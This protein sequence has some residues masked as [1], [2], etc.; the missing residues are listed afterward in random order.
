V[1]VKHYKESGIENIPENMIM[2]KAFTQSTILHEIIE[3]VLM[4]FG[5]DFWRAHNFALDSERI[6]GI[7]KDPHSEN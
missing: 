4:S 3:F 5:I 2:S 7:L 6:A 1:D